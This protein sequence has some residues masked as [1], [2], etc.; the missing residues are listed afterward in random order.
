MYL[1]IV[2]QSFYINVPLSLF[3]IMKQEEIRPI[4]NFSYA[5]LT[6]LGDKA[7]RL[8]LRDLN[9]LALYGIDANIA[10]SIAAQTLA[11]K[12][13]PTDYELVGLVSEATKHKDNIR[14]QMHVM[15][16]SIM[17]RVKNK[18]GIGSPTYKRFGASELSNQSDE[19]IVHTARR[20]IRLSTEYLPS[21]AEKGLTQTIIDSL[22]SILLTFDNSIDAKAAAIDTRDESTQKRITIANALYTQISEVFDYGKDY[23]YTRDE[24][25]YNDY[26]IYDNPTSNL[27]DDTNFTDDIPTE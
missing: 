13:Y 10:N 22:N 18:Y 21:L 7:E 14:D 26:I 11:F 19:E 9:D 27:P 4:F 8:I 15:I 16:S 20:V 17:I 6:Q 5:Q 23:Y 2:I 1:C 25:K 24:A 12:K 3:I